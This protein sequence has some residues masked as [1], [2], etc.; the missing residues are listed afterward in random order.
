MAAQVRK[1]LGKR[2][3]IV[4]F[5]FCAT[6]YRNNVVEDGRLNVLKEQRVEFTQLIQGIELKNG[7][8]FTAVDYHFQLFNVVK[9]DGLPK[10]VCRGWIIV[11][12]FENFHETLGKR[13]IEVRMANHVPGVAPTDFN[14]SDQVV[15]IGLNA[16]FF[17]GAAGQLGRIACFPFVRRERIHGE[18]IVGRTNVAVAQRFAHHHKR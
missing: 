14:R 10:L 11:F 6:Q 2:I 17:G 7:A 5:G 12:R 3:N 16:P 8:R 15:I 4:N 13:A 9:I 18:V 1:T